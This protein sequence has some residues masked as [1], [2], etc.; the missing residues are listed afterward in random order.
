MRVT[1]ITALLVGASLVVAVQTEGEF[2]GFDGVRIRYTN[3]GQG[4]AVVL[5]HGANHMTCVL[6]PE[7]R[8]AIKET[9]DQQVGT[10]NGEQ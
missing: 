8:Q 9:L 3:A 5:I 10:E 6:R 7:F 1:V 4:P 2:M